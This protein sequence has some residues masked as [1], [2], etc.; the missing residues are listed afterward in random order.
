MT[1]EVE[2]TSLFFYNIFKGDDKMKFLKDKR[3]LEINETR[4]EDAA[5][6][7]EYLKKVG[8]ESNNLSIDKGGVDLTVEQEK[9]RLEKNKLSFNNKSFVAKVDK[10][11]ISVSGI[12]GSQRERI[13][14]NVG[15]G[16]SVLKDFWNLGVA[17]HVMKYIINYCRMSVD[18]EVINIEVRED[19]KIAIKLYENL[20]FKKV[21]K[22]TNMF[23]VEH[24]YFDCIIMELI[25]RQ[26]WNILTNALLLRL[27]IFLFKT[28]ISF[29]LNE[30]II[31]NKYEVYAKLY[32]GDCTD[33]N[34][35]YRTDW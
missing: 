22:Y 8:S 10:K 19:N 5:E 17:T 31:Y 32:K 21:G 12:H 28:W 15:L 23:K 33:E 18:I 29:D 16:I 6:V 20:G 34:R 26:E 4:P 9:E 35:H 13:K 14:H 27:C 7:L 3:I 30:I 24:K 1:R 2:K 11:I 25:I